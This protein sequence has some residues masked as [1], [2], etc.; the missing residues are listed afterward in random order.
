[1]I[2]DPAA[3]GGAVSAFYHFATAL[4]VGSAT[5]LVLVSL[6]GPGR[7]FFILCTLVGLVFYALAFVGGG[8]GVGYLHLACAG[9]LVAYNVSLPRQGSRLSSPILWAAVLLG[10]AGLVLDALAERGTAPGLG[11][12]A[13]AHLAAAAVA[14]SALMGSSLAAMVLGHWYL[15]TRGLSFELL[16]RL[17]LALGAAVAFR[18]L[19]AGA[20]SLEQSERFAELWR[21]LG[22]ATFGLQYGFFIAARVLFGLLAPL[23]LTG[24]ALACVREHSNQSATGILY[25]VLAFVLIGEIIQR[26]LLA[27]GGILV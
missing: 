19:A 8:L 11:S 2:V 4:A 13:G 5:P 14:S 17:V 7:R 10:N 23:A 20:A 3:P 12:A 18:A 1:L 9:L 16:R 22:P 24:M 21:T 27:S 25:V 6:S 15:V 26:H